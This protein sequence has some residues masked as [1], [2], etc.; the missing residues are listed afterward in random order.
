MQ[1]MLEVADWSQAFDLGSSLS[2]GVGLNPTAVKLFY[3]HLYGKL[4]S[5]DIEQVFTRICSISFNCVNL[6]PTGR[7]QTRKDFIV[8]IF[9]FLIN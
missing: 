6:G 7:K 8:A 2:G 4:C 9:P 5:I 3:F 1:A